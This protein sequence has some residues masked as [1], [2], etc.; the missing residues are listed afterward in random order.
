MDL[1]RPCEL[2]YDLYTNFKYL[3]ED[4]LHAMDLFGIPHHYYLN[5]EG[6]PHLQTAQLVHGYFKNITLLH[7][8]RYCMRREGGRGGSGW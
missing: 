6:H 8:T 1:C 5:R 4:A 2:D 3:P 7:K